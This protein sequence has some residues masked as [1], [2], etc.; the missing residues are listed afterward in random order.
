[1]ESRSAGGFHGTWPGWILPALAKEIALWQ[2]T[3]PGSNSVLIEARASSG[4]EI[5]FCQICETASI[6]H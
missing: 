1:M 6:T 3:G 5:E 4:S 2:P